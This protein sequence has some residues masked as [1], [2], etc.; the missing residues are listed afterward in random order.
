MRIY[1]IVGL[2][3]LVLLPLA[4]QQRANL[5]DES[6]IS[7]LISGPSHDAAF[8]LYGHAAFRIKDPMLNFDNIFNYGIFDF[9]SSN[10]IYRFAKGETDYKL[11]ATDFLGYL[12]EYQM[13]GS[14]V[15][16]LVL[17][18][19]T[20]EKNKIW[21]ALLINYLPENRVY[22]Y[23]FFFDNCATRLVDIVEKHLDGDVVY[24]INQ[25]EET[26]RELINHCTREHA[27]LTFGCDLAL[28]SPTDRIATPR[29]KMFLPE[30]LEKAFKTAEIQFADGSKRPLV[31]QVI[32]LAAYDPEINNYPPERLTP[33]LCSLLIFFI[34][35]G[36][37]YVGWKRKKAFKGLDIILFSLAGVAGCVLFFLSFISTHPAVFPNYSLF[38]LHPLHLLG[39]I[40]ITVKKETKAAYYYHFINFVALTLLLPAWIFIPQH[41]N[42]AFVPLILSLWIR[43]GYVVYRYKTWIKE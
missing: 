35:I 4:A 15:T 31:K 36:I 21:D 20:E 8:T 12:I 19:T 1:I 30:Q 14:S 32:L 38:W 27:W 5:S 10:F 13:R 2:F 37:T 25:P 39:A 42:I 22:R 40:L 11:G 18:L 41:L 28:G 33:L 29:E 23:N 9:S 16:E 7:V 43:S 6:E 26:F 24:K 34:T 17:N 3:L